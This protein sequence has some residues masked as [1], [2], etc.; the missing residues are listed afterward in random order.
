VRTQSCPVFLARG[1]AR[2]VASTAEQ[3]GLFDDKEGSRDS[4]DIVINDR[5]RIQTRESCRVVAIC[6]L[7]LVHYV[8]GDRM[9]EAHAMV[10]LVEQGWAKQNEVAAAFGCTERTVRRNQRRFESGGLAALGRQTG[11][12]KGT[13]RLPA[14]R[15][16]LVNEWKSE[17]IANRE[18]ARRLGVT[19]KA[20]RKVLRRLGWKASQGEQISL[21]LDPAAADPNLSDRSTVQSISDAHRGEN[22]PEEASPNADPKL[23]GLDA[24][25]W[26]AS[27]NGPEGRAQCPPGSADPNLSGSDASP[28]ELLPVSLDADAADRSLDRILACL[29]MLEDAAPV[30]GNAVHIDGVGVL[31]AIP[32]LV[33]SGV[34][35][36]ANDIYGSIGPAFYGL[37][38][39]L[40]TLLL[41]ALLRIKRPEGLKEHSPRALGQVLGLDRAPEV[42]T[43]R[44]KLARLA[45]FGRAADFGRALAQHRV[46]VR[47]PAMGF[48]YVDGHVRAYHGKRQ[49]PKAHL[50]R[51]RL[52]MPATT[53]YWVNDAEGEP[54]FVVTTEANEGLVKML[55][56]VL[57]EVRPLVGDRRVTVVFDRGGWSPKLFK[58]LLTRGFDILTYRK[59]RCPRLP[60]SAFTV[61]KAV[62]DEQPT[63][64]RLADQGTYLGYGPRHARHRLHLRQVIR[65]DD[66]GHQTQVITSRR[67][68][69][70]IEVA[71]RM[72]ARWRQ[73]NFF[74]YLREEY[75]L[76]ALVDYGVE[77][78]DPTREVPNPVRKQ[79]N[80]EL[81]RAYAELSQL[82]AEYGSEAFV[83]R[84]QL[85]RTMRGFKIANA[86]L[87]R[88]IRESTER[89]AKLERRRDAT[90]ARVPLQPLVE[91]EV[92]KL[93]VER[94]HISDLLKMVAYQAEGELVRLVTPHYRRADDEARTLVHSALACVGD[95]QVADRQLRISLEPLSSPHRTH[96]LAELCDQ[97]NQTPTPFPGSKLLLH[98]EVK[99]PPDTSLAFPGPRPS[100]PDRAPNRTF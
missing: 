56:V 59:G 12:P 61:H 8:V 74:K 85:R 96:A 39:T 98:Y 28:G 46:A 14:T 43:L 94:K 83:N 3:S 1:H 68:L 72:F 13:S 27:D 88:R 53:D 100:T 84:E 50:A 5:C 21:D 10:S 48:L 41:M 62:L 86:A 6:G 34:F 71:H 90:P 64:Y 81:R 37:R 30:F 9:G 17:G 95:I 20:V 18:I 15:M 73:E 47:G 97:L 65:L 44:R 42:K 26:A 54:L 58:E 75:A 55:P 22:R 29:G 45:A 91:G 49:L 66:D 57:D 82:A 69:P 63:S 33:D 52:A 80:G 32:A 78:A 70:A 40:L 99:P 79:L 4:S 31:L 25:Q 76:D 23:S 92:I 77:P 89:I 16:R 51:M 67:D 19:D 11:Y 2:V 35:K 36:I 7:P 87:R 60:D 93:R 24:G 38:T